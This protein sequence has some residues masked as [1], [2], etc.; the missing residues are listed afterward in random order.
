M[1]PQF[2]Y[3]KRGNFLD[4]WTPKKNL[5][6]YKAKRTL[7]GH[8][9]EPGLFTGEESFRFHRVVV[10]ISELAVGSRQL[11]ETWVLTNHYFSNGTLASLEFDKTIK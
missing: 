1:T 8:P 4:V 7:S 5:G 11:T 9:C 3:Q 6:A 2:V 10:E